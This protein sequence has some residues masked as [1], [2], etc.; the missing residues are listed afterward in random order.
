M[1]DSLQQQT[2]DELDKKAGLVDVQLHGYK[3]PGTR[4]QHG[5][6]MS[7][8]LYTMMR[9]GHLD[10]GCLRA[11]YLHA[12]ADTI[13]TAMVEN[14]E[15]RV[16]AAEAQVAARAA[17]E[18][19]SKAAP[20]VVAKTSTKTA[21]TTSTTAATMVATTA[22]SATAE[23]GGAASAAAE[24]A[25]APA[26]APAPASAATPQQAAVATTT[27]PAALRALFQT[28]CAGTWF[29]HAKWD[30]GA[31]SEALHVHTLSKDG[32]MRFEYEDDEQTGG[33]SISFTGDTTWLTPGAGDRNRH[34]WQLH[35]I[36]SRA[37]DG[38]SVIG[39]EWV[40]QNKKRIRWSRLQHADQPRGSRSATAAQAAAAVK[41]AAG[42]TTTAQHRSKE[43]AAKQCYCRHAECVGL[44][45]QLAQRLRQSSGVHLRALTRV[46]RSQGEPSPVKQFTQQRTTLFLDVCGAAKRTEASCGL[47]HFSPAVLEAVV[48]LLKD[49]ASAANT[50]LP[51]MVPLERVKAHAP[52][53]ILPR[54]A[55]FSA[56]TLP[57]KAWWPAG[58]ERGV[59]AV[60]IINSID[61]AADAHRLARDA[62]PPMVP[63]TPA[64]RGSSKV[65]TASASRSTESGLV[66]RPPRRKRASTEVAATE[67]TTPG[68]SSTESQTLRTPTA[69]GS[70]PLGSPS[71]PTTAERFI[72]RIAQYWGRTHF[73]ELPTKPTVDALAEELQGG[74]AAISAPL[75][76]VA[77]DSLNRWT[78]TDE[79][80][81]NQTQKKKTGLTYAQQLY[82]F[83]NYH[84]LVCHAW[85]Y[86]PDLAFTFSKPGQP[87][88]QWEQ[89]C[90]A[91]M[92]MRTGRSQQDLEQ[93]LGRPPRLSVYLGRWTSRW[94]EAEACIISRHVTP[95]LI[96]AHQIKGF[97]QRY[98]K[99]IA[100]VV[101]G[102][103]VNLGTARK[104]SVL[105]RSTWSNKA[106]TN[107]AQGLAWI[108][109][110]GLLLVNS[111]LFNG[112][113]SEKATVW[114]HR[115]LL[116][117]F[118]PGYAMLVDRGFASCTA[119]YKNLIQGLF[120]AF[121]KD[122][123]RKTILDA[124][125][126]SADRYV[127]ETFF[128]RVKN[129]LMLAGVVPV[130]RAWLLERAW[131]CALAA[132][133]L[134]AP[135]REPASWEA[136]QTGIRNSSEQL[137]ESLRN[138]ADGK[139][140]P[141]CF[142]PWRQ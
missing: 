29:S 12:C 101:D 11:S 85:V 19:A 95:E 5:D 113:L 87:L 123:C 9:L 89:C 141:W 128:S 51:P 71:P 81:L 90:A 111:S 6:V 96:D 114:L 125:K 105:A 139:P 73:H 98:K 102:S 60:P 8:Q 78:L 44:S 45:S 62:A 134:Y 86:F 20:T 43:P 92:M 58:S 18:A 64:P 28:R 91:R 133:D 38:D 68:Q 24:A 36:L 79:M 63:A 70:R 74:G 135:L 46:R 34:R 41:A 117:V 47:V 116:G 52:T 25:P 99:K 94:Y 118:P 115:E 1:A 21:A 129:F 119:A 75:V 72:P 124:K 4:Q 107:A 110:A 136:T 121:A 84:E 88:T 61:E 32:V 97:D 82:G 27:A 17:T 66:D 100:C 142:Q 80:Y 39:C 140:V 53:L 14:H 30:I 23:S 59:F 132:T 106:Q 3:F 13:Q 15:R 137:K 57:P 69:S 33:G 108:S 2:R 104:N 131:V 76:A 103:T 120:P 130:E 35:C 40:G 49:S 83:R 26:P 7:S 31:H 42:I 16:A 37:D 55:V 50:A 122:L 127:V 126:Q 22:A 109:P 77:R 54:G 10:P 48:D 138:E 93:I 56:T 65:G 67:S 112:R